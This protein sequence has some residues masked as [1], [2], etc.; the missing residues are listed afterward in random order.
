VEIHVLHGA[1]MVGSVS[2]PEQLKHRLWT[3][4]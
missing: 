4:V 3:C 1:E 2:Q